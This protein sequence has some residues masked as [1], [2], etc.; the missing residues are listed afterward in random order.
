[1]GLFNSLFG[2]SWSEKVNQYML[3]E[4]IPIEERIRLCILNLHHTATT[5]EIVKGLPLTEIQK[6]LVGIDNEDELSNLALAISTRKGLRMPVVF[7]K[8][9]GDSKWKMIVITLPNQL[10]DDDELRYRRSEKADTII[11]EPIYN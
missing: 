1:M 2:P 10:P 6:H 3:N 8:E 4:N 7:S 5:N 9:K 11:W